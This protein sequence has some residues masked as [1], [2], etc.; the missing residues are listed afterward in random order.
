[1]LPFMGIY[2]VTHENDL[3]LQNLVYP[4]PHPINP[5]LGVHFTLT[6]AYKVKICP[7]AISIAGREHCSF[8]YGQSARDINQAIKGMISLIQVEIHDF[9]SIIKQIGGKLAS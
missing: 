4:V 5:F 1:M 3:P 9:A 8:L 7:T 2:R 6:I